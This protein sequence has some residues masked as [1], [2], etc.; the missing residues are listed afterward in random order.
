MFPSKN[1]VGMSTHPLMPLDA[2]SLYIKSKLNFSKRDF[3]NIINMTAK[4][5]SKF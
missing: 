5:N 1:L 3:Y 2:F 4:D